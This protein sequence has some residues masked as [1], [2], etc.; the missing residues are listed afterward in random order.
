MFKQRINNDEI[1]KLGVKIFLKKSEKFKKI[2]VS[3][4]KDYLYCYYYSNKYSYINN[5]LYKKIKFSNRYYLDIIFKITLS[6]E[7]FNF[8]NVCLE[9]LDMSGYLEVLKV[10]NNNIIYLKKRNYSSKYLLNFILKGLGKKCK[11]IKFTTRP[12]VK[13]FG[14]LEFIEIYDYEIFNSLYK[15]GLIKFSD[16]F[17]EL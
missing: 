15:K 16:K 4:F 2:K 12:N 7:F 1:L 11:K 14:H 6:N 17:S 8:E 9:F 5:N 10:E 13:Y 3:N